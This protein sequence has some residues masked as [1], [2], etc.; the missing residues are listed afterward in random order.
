MPTLELVVTTNYA[1]FIPE[2]PTLPVPEEIILEKKLFDDTTDLLQAVKEH[3]AQLQSDEINLWDDVALFVYTSG[4]TGR[5]KGAMLT[6]GNALF[7][8]A[9]AFH[10]NQSEK[11]KMGLT[12]MPIF[13]IAGMVMGVNIPVYSGMTTVMLTRYDAQAVVTAIEKYQCDFWYSIA[14]MNGELLGYPGIEKR[15]LSSLKLNLCT[16]FGFPVNQELSDA[17]KQLTNGCYLYEASYGLSE[18]HTCDTIMPPEKI[19]FG[20]CG[21]PTFDTEVK[22]LD[23]ETGDPLPPGEQGEI[24]IKNPGVFKGYFNR[25][26]ATDETLK[27]GWVYTGD[28]GMIDQDGYLYFIGRVKEMIKC[29]GYSVFPEDVEA[30]L[31]KHPAVL[32]AG[33]IGVPDAR[34]G[35]SVKAF[36][37][38]KQDFKGKVSAED[39]IT[40][41]K[42]KKAAY[43]DPRFVEFRDSLPATG[44]GKVLRRLLKEA[45]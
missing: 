5:P 25:P 1:D 34:R 26:Q 10:G 2:E 9:A 33:V 11:L 44:T 35:E 21:I 14:P 42:E 23:P 37:V 31:I 32:Q 6:Y 19:K 7:K 22:I 27:D 45:Q 30:M 41:S 40:W 18:T 43:K 16:S 36:I 29:S 17:W 39:I 8:T 28:I 38:L 4:T 3:S 13:H 24:V 20:S 15:D 12:V